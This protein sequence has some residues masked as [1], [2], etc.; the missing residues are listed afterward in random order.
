MSKQREDQLAEL[1]EVAAQELVKLIKSGEASSSDYKNAIQFLKDNGITCEAKR[2][3][4][5]SELAEVLP[6]T[7]AEAAGDEGE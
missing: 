2:G 6:F 5:L 1:F 4:P 3:N 7:R